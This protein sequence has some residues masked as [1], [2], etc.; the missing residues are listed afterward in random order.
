MISVVE[1]RLRHQTWRPSNPRLFRTLNVINTKSRTSVSSNPHSKGRVA[2]APA[3][4]TNE[5][6]QAPSL[7]TKRWSL[8][9]LADARTKGKEGGTVPGYRLAASEGAGASTGRGQAVVE[10]P[11]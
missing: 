3:T 7:L 8:R 6:G 1:R 4:L 10:V 2:G 5:G 9:R 11:A